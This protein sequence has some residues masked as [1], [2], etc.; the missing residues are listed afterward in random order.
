MHAG[1]RPKIRKAVR[2]IV[3]LDIISVAGVVA[4]I[5]VAH[6]ATR[7]PCPADLK[8]ILIGLLLVGGLAM[9]GAELGPIAQAAK[10]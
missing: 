1:G 7:A 9:L 2:E 10:L 4:G 6:R 5:A 8:G 3:M